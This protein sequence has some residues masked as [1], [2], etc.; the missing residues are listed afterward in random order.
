MTAANDLA[1]GIR[2]ITEVESG[3]GVRLRRHRIN[4]RDID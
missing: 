2:H 1:V 4:R 3:F